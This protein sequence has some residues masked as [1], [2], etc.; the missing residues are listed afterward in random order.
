MVDT[1]SI[2][3]SHEYG[4]RVCRPYQ[5]WNVNNSTTQTDCGLT[6]YT[7]RPVSNGGIYIHACNINEFEFFKI[8]MLYAFVCTVL[9]ISIS[10]PLSLHH[11]V[12]LNQKGEIVNL[13][14]SMLKIVQCVITLVRF[15]VYG[16]GVEGPIS[17]L[18]ERIFWVNDALVL[19]GVDVLSLR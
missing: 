9:Q 4:C 7:I 12:V 14:L 11:N 15:L 19:S 3:N 10:L 13:I 18:L 6:C 2:N 5:T 16:H 1:L 8:I 17:C